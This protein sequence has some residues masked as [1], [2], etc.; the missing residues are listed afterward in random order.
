MNDYFSGV[1]TYERALIRDSEIVGGARQ[2]VEGAAKHVAKYGGPCDRVWA[3][4][5]ARSKPLCS[6]TWHVDSGSTCGVEE[7]TN[8]GV[9]VATYLSTGSL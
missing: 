1:F 5:M 6:G 9:Q 7:K 2:G 8:P 3:Q 4:R